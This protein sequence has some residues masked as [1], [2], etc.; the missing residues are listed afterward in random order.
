MRLS[1]PVPGL[2]RPAPWQTPA[3]C[4]SEATHFGS[5]LNKLLGDLLKATR[6]EDDLRSC[7]ANDIAGKF[8]AFDDQ[9]GIAD[10]GRDIRVRYLAK[11]KRAA[12]FRRD[13]IV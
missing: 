6:F 13:E 4:D 1:L 3:A 2:L 11:D 8:L 7:V 12:F 5:V 9:A 10:A